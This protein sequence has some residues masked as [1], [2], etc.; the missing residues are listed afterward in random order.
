MFSGPFPLHVLVHTSPDTDILVPRMSKAWGCERLGVRR[1]TRVPFFFF[2][3]HRTNVESHIAAGKN[4]L[5][6]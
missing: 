3:C 5:R 2:F 1:L 6:E 4:T